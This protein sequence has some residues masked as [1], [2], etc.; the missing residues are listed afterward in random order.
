MK[1]GSGQMMK[2]NGLPQMVVELHD[3]CHFEPPPEGIDIPFI[4]LTDQERKD[5]LSDPL[6]YVLEKITEKD[7]KRRME[8]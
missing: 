4:T 8:V 3:D 2:G 6:R 5:Y 1:S 7:F